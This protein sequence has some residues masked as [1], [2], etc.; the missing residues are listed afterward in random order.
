MSYITTSDLRTLKQ[1]FTNKLPIPELADTLVSYPNLTS[2]LDKNILKKIPANTLLQVISSYPSTAEN[3][4][5]V[6]KSKVLND[7]ILFL[8]DKEKFRTKEL[9]YNKK[10]VSDFY[11]YLSERQKNNYLDITQY[12]CD[13]FNFTENT[14]KLLV[15]LPDTQNRLG[16]HLIENYFKFMKPDS[17][18]TL[19]KYNTQLLQY[20]KLKDLTREMIKTISQQTLTNENNT[21]TITLQ[22]IFVESAHKK[23]ELWKS[24]EVFGLLDKGLLKASQFN[25]CFDSNICQ[26]ISTY[27]DIQLYNRIYQLPD[28]LKTYAELVDNDISLIKDRLKDMIMEHLNTRFC[29]N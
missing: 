9:D 11:Y 4:T 2:V 5:E 10:E 19:W 29:L 17:C 22:S 20:I 16:F 26:L 15:K 23:P 6:S 12:T 25:N 21:N 13:Q 8:T 14:L 27:Q 7:M 18:K 28:S 1:V 24:T 3:L